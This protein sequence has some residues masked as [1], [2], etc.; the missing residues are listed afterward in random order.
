MN[1]TT[2]NKV[3]INKDHKVIIDNRKKITITNVSKAV[4]A[5]ETS[6]ILELQTTKCYVSGKN[7]HISKLDV[8]EGVAEITGEINSFKY[9][10]GESQNFFKRLFK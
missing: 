8:E 4:S 1:T 2:E 3:K 9:A 10:G 5:N 6:V 7:L